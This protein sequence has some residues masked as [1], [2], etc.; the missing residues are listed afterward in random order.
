[1]DALYTDPTEFDKMYHVKDTLDEASIFG[2][3]GITE[4]KVG[5]LDYN[6]DNS[7]PQFIPFF[8]DAV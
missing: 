3:D 4:F 8:P 6:K 7:Y 5:T 1:M 2:K